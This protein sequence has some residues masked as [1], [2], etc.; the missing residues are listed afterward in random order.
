MSV[1]WYAPLTCWGLKDCMTFTASLPQPSFSEKNSL[2]MDCQPGER[3]QVSFFEV[4]FF[5]PGSSS[6]SNRMELASRWILTLPRICRQE[7]SQTALNLTLQRIHRPKILANILNFDFT[8]T[9]P[10]RIY[11]QEPTSGNSPPGIPASAPIFKRTGALLYTL[12]K[13]RRAAVRPCS[14]EAMRQ[15]D[16]GTTL[17]PSLLIFE[18]VTSKKRQ[19]L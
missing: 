18:F 1:T 9:P 14:S 2:T 16:S 19:H 4:S 8:E 6:Y 5:P 15:Y 11:S 17:V 13:G 10:P 3:V 12:G 7:F